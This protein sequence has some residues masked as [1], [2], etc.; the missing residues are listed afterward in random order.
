MY[1]LCCYKTTVEVYLYFK[2]IYIDAYIVLYWYIHYFHALI[3]V[4]FNYY[5]CIKSSEFF[6]QQLLDY[7]A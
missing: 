3:S 4:K 5:S 1:T 2:Y 6:L 7:C